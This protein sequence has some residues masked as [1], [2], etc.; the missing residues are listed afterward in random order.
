MQEESYS[1][2]ETNSNQAGS[3][4]LEM[5]LVP[6]SSAASAVSKIPEIHLNLDDLPR[7]SPQ[8]PK[9]AIKENQ[10]NDAKEGED[11][12][13]LNEPE[14][15]TWYGIDPRSRRPIYPHSFSQ[16]CA[17]CSRE[18]GLSL[19]CRYLGNEDRYW[20]TIDSKPRHPH[21]FGQIC[22]QCANEVGIGLWC[23]FTMVKDS[24]IAKLRDKKRC[25]D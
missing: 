22:P 1:D 23:R 24:Y 12:W 11:E 4:N 5:S 2:S 15:D 8:E 3:V 14:V 6:R 16:D 25:N 9:R 17:Q 19:G 18:H 13:W 10:T 21:S 7:G 20:N